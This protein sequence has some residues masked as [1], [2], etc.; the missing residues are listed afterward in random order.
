ML[1]RLVENWLTNAG[2]RGYEVAFAQ[3][4]A[5][6]GHSV[7]QGPVHHPFEHGKDIL[8]VSAEGQLHAYQLKGPDLRT[9]DEFEKIQPQLLALA[10][11]GITHPAVAPPR[12]PDRVFLVTSAKL[13][14]PVRD[15]IEKFNFGNTPTGLPPIEPIELEQLTKRFV[16]AHGAYMPQE[17]PDIQVLIELYYS[18]PTTLSRSRDLRA[19]RLRCCP[20]H[21]ATRRKQTFAE[22]WRAPRS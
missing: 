22:R 7:L 10:A 17:L 21:R 20:F 1:E 14:P 15:R 4:L 19:I 8:T 16:L 12:R 9:L 11:A 13:T 18:D 6:E 5:A 2:E 3:L